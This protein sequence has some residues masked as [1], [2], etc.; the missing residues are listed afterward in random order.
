MKRH[1]LTLVALVFLTT[2]CAQETVNTVVNTLK[3]RIKLMGYTQ[4]GYTYNDAEKADNSF[5]VKRIILMA[6]GNITDKWSCYFMY[7]LNAG[8]TLI[9]VYTDYHFI[10][11]LSAR[12]GQFQIP[13]TFEGPMSTS[14]VELIECYSQATNYY[15][16]V[17]GNHDP[18]K[19]GTGGRDIGLQFYGNFLNKRLTYNLAILNGQ[20]IN[21]GDR[22]S[23]KDIVAALAVSPLEW[24]TVG[25]S[26]IKGKG[27]AVGISETNPDILS[28]QN[29]KRDRWAI[30]AMMK[31]KPLS[32]RAEYLGGKDEK[33]KSDGYYATASFHV[34]PKFDIIASYDYLN[35]NK[36][37]ELKQT[38][39][40]AGVQY[41]FYPRCRVQAQYIYSE[42]HKLENSNMI[43]TQV[44][45]R[46]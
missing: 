5:D 17:G 44:Q 26:F 15:M 4:V 32:L 22:N 21:T 18:L 33:V 42:K 30:S 8:G 37:L 25:G 31:T 6:E 11:G 41:W 12:L 1:L 24:L 14:S 34:F 20:G 29:Y 28:G 46:F 40:I 45:V 2:L 27:H 3:E 7:N 35:K 23:N 9:E 19:G 38:N 43:Q 16:A 10:P 39:Y 13:F 36:T